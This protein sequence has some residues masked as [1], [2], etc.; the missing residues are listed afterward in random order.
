MLAKGTYIYIYTY[1][2]NL[3]IY[4][5]IYVYVHVHARASACVSCHRPVWPKE[6]QR[7]IPTQYKASLLNYVLEVCRRKVLRL[8][9][10]DYETD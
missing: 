10:A 2:H 1:I 3:Y 8:T 7:I 9:R 5:C 4:I 6:S